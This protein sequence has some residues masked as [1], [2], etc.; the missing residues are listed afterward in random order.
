MDIRF[1]RECKDMIDELKGKFNGMSIEI[2]K[3]IKL[4]RLEQVTNLSTYP[5]QCFKSFCYDDDDDY[6]YEEK[7]IPLRDIISELPLSIAITSVLPTLEPEDSLIMGDEELSNIPEKES[8]RIAHKKDIECKVS[9]DY[10]LDELTFLVTPLFDSNEHECF[11]P[12]DDIELLLHRDPSTPMISKK[13]LYDNPIDDL[14]FDPGGDV[15]EIDAFLDID[16][17]TNIKDGF[18]DSEGDVLY[19][20]SLLSDDTTPSPPPEV[21]LDRDP[22]SLRDI[23]DLKIMVKVFD[24]MIH[25]KNSSPTYVS[26]TFEDRHYLSFTY[27]IRIFLPY[28]TYPVDS[29]LPFSSGSSQRLLSLLKGQEITEVE[30]RSVTMVG[31]IT[32]VEW[33]K[34]TEFELQKKSEI[35]DDISENIRLDASYWTVQETKQDILQVE[36]LKC[37]NESLNLPVEELSKARALVEATLR[38]RDKMISAQ[39]K[40]IRLLEEQCEIF[41][42]VPSEFDSEIVHDTQD[43]SEKDVI[44]SL[45]T[46]LKK[47]AELVVCF[48]DEKYCAL[49]E[50]ESLKVEIKSLQTENK[51]LKS[52]KSELSE[53]I[54][55]MKS[56]VSELSE[57]LQISA[58][59]MKQQIIL[60]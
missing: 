38:K 17:S 5:S 54:D 25:E 8:D 22:R 58:Q 41:H 49:K 4:Q 42:E 3:K 48:S 33:F 19:L 53:K 35:I 18:Y 24:S 39:C 7:S 60:F 15:D 44:L 13:I 55:Q 1:R 43:N 57:K 14:I 30:I 29:S 56:Q 12:S 40:K 20:E 46:Q 47:T 37:V 50:T 34:R 26:L 2:N 16:I 59:E 52:G 51:V 10:N 23:N 21:F 28:F 27:V 31:C 6:D 32:D 11:T 45:L 9:Y 36:E